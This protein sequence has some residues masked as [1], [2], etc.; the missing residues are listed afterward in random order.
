MAKTSWRK[1]IPLAPEF[2]RKL[3]GLIAEKG[4]SVAAEWLGLGRGSVLRAA[5]GV[6]LRR[7]TAFVIEMKLKEV[8]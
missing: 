1:G 6:G 8:A 3:R 5:A 4:E 2:Q 7:G